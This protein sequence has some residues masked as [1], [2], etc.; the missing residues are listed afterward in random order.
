VGFTVRGALN[1]PTL[2]LDG[3][4]AGQVDLAALY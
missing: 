3:A 4:I 2:G 1:L